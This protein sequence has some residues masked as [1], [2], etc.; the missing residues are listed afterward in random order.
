MGDLAALPLT[1]RVSDAIGYVS[2]LPEST[3]GVVMATF[4][5]T[6]KYVWSVFGD[7][8]AGDLALVALMMQQE[9]L[10]DE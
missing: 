3:R 4:D 10:A 8:Q 9:A 2:A 7:V 1:A 5:E 6:G